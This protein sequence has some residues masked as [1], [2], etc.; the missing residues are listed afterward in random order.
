M[1]NMEN[2]KEN[3]N[4]QVNIDLEPMTL[5][6]KTTKKAKKTRKR[7]ISYMIMVASFTTSMGALV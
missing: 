1:P 2:S 6:V 7:T 5:K 3:E 4:V